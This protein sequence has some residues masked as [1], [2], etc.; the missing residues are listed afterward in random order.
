MWG[1]GAGDLM[2]MGDLAGILARKVAK[3]TPIR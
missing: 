3:N 2:G 1:N